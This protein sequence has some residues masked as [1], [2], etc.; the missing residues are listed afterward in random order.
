MNTSFGNRR[1]ALQWLGSAGASGVLVPCAMSSASSDLPV[2]E[3][4]RGLVVGAGLGGGSAP[5]VVQ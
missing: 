4:G 2:N 3:L 5:K 1:R